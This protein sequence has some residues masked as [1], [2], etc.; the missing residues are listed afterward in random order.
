MNLLEELVEDLGDR[1]TTVDN[2]VHRHIVG[3]S[4]RIE[5][6]LDAM[7]YVA[8]EVSSMATLVEWARVES[9]S[10][11]EVFMKHLGPGGIPSSS[12]S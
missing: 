11:L 1:C 2:T 3:L 4:V 5:H 9:L 10:K 12:S 8:S 7:S 6:A